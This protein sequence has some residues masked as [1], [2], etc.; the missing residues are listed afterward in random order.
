MSEARRAAQSATKIPGKARAAQLRNLTP[1]IRGPHPPAQLAVLKEHLGYFVRRLQIS[2]FQDFI[3]TLSRID[4]SP[5]QFSV[6]VVI[7]ANRGLSQALLAQ[8]LGIERA[9]LARLLHRL[10]SRGLI[11]RLQ[12][13]ND[14]RR[15][16]L[17]LTPEGRTL[18]T[19][20]KNLA[21]KHEQRLVEKLGADR[22]DLLLNALRDI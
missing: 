10:E 20:A 9:R 19:R 17:Q 5:A 22:H 7:S 8:T 12:S 15:H 21:A 14:G 18:L 3:R 1:T 11:L 16:A 6:L 4:I 2:I 13:A